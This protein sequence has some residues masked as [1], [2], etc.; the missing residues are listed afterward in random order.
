MKIRTLALLAV[1]V[2]QLLYGLNYTLAKDVMVGG[3]VKPFGFIVLR[4]A[5]ATILFWLLS[6][7][8][9]KEKIDKRDYIR[10]FIAAIF[11][12][13]INMLLFF[14]GLQLTTPIHASVI[15]TISPILVLIMSAFFLK[16]KVTSLKILGVIFG[17]TGAIILT[18]YGKSLRAADNVPLGNALV[19]VNAISYSIYI[20]LIKRLTDKYHPL[21]FIKWLFLFGLIMVLP[22][23]YSEVMEI[24]LQTFTPFVTFEVLFVIIGATFG[25][26]LLNPLALRHLKASTVTIFIYIQP[27]VAGVVSIMMGS[28]YLGTVKIIATC[29]IFLGVYL[30]TKRPKISA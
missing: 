30:V 15:A 28:D 24:D 11:G 20:V 29:L 8:G 7:L 27:V 25:T 17:F 23:G 22:F 12:I 2:V 5:G 10:F 9:P 14:K 19:M 1:L 16:E 4:V 21:T 3:H 18:V 13:A 6:F 26:Y